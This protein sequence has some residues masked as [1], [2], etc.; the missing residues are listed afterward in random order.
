MRVIVDPAPRNRTARV[1]AVTVFLV[2]FVVGAGQASA[3]PGITVSQSQGLNPAGDTITVSGSGFDVAK[4]IY[5][6]VCVDNGPG[7]VPTPCLGGVDTSG[8]G[9]GSAW[10]SSNPPSYGAGLTTPYGP[11]GSFSVTLAVAAVDPVTGTDCRRIACAAITRTDHTRTAD[12]SQDARVPL[13]FA[14][15]ATPK[16]AP[17]PAPEPTRPPPPPPTTTT[18]TTTAAPTTTTTTTTEP[19]PTSTTTSA[20][21]APAAA[22]PAEPSR[23]GWWIGG[24]AAALV[25]AIVLVVPRV[26]RGRVTPTDPS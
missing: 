12:R 14:P 7:Q 1:L 20:E 24:A 26:R 2:T 4:G 25:A 10:I 19:S 21:V 23:T 15:P 13:T 5:V 3:A 9:G 18:T 22:A 11:G 6:A 17:E 16:K 8:A